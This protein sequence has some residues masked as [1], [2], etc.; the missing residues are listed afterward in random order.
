MV[1]LNT[2]PKR[3]SLVKMNVLVSFYTV[4]NCFHCSNKCIKDAEYIFFITMSQTDTACVDGTTDCDEGSIIVDVIEVPK[5]PPLAVDDPI[6][7][8]EDTPVAI[9]PLI[10]DQS[11]SDSPLK[12]VNVTNG[13]N[14]SCEI[15]EDT[16]TFTPNA[17]FDG[18]DICLY[19]VC[20]DNELCDEG[21]SL[22]V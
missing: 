1:K 18:V 6:S 8:E 12:L 21:V 2:R 4:V 17:G 16:V 3:D 15:N 10:N 5:E 20:D 19:T 7:T 22:V 13:E 11:P 14:G 9:D